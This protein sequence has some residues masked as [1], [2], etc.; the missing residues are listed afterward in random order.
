MPGK[1]KMVEYFV[2]KIKED[3]SVKIEVYTGETIEY[4]CISRH[5]VSE[6]KKA[7]DVIDSN[8]STKCYSNSS[9]FISS[10][11]YLAEQNNIEIE[12]FLNN[13]SVGSD[14]EPIFADLN[15]SFD[16]MKSLINNV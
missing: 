4:Y 13:I 1:V 7:K 8:K 3:D 16:L 11:K 5:P 15:R 6:V 14:I 2:P 10:I 12:F 9:D